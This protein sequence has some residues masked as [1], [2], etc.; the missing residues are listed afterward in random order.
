MVAELGEAGGA[1]LGRIAA[2]QPR[3]VAPGVEL[4]LGQRSLPGDQRAADRRERQGVLD[5]DRERGAGA[6]CDQVVGLAVR[7]VA[8]QDLRTFGH[9]LD[10]HQA[11]SLDER[12][13]RVRLLADRVEQCPRHLGA[14]E[15]QDQAGDAASGAEIERLPRPDGIEDRQRR[16]RIEQVEMCDRPRLDDAGEVQPPV[17]VEQERHEPLGGIGE[18]GRQLQMARLE[19]LIEG[20]ARGARIGLGQRNAPS[21]DLS[22]FPADGRRRGRLSHR[23]RTIRGYRT[24]SPGEAG[25]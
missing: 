2:E 8:P 24:R 25:R 15:G 20:M 16:Q 5:Q 14:G 1:N 7:R 23:P 6:G 12:A 17:G 10:V 18:A 22:V 4:D 19:R 21:S 3:G 11:Q 9:D 13:H